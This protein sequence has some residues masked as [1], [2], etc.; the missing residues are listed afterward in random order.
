MY[1]INKLYKKLLK[2]E[3]QFIFMMQFQNIIYKLNV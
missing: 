2:N 3:K 1:K